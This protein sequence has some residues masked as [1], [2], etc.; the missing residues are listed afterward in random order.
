MYDVDKEKNNWLKPILILLGIVVVIF[1]VLFAVKA[2]DNNKK[3]DGSLESILL[4]AGKESFN[5]EGLPEA[6]GECRTVTLGSLVENDYIDDV[7]VFAT[8]DNAESY[9]KVCKLESGEYQYT[10]VLNCTDNKTSFTDWVVGTE[11]SL[12]PNKSDVR[13]TYLAER[14]EMVGDESKVTSTSKK[15]FYP[16]NYTSANKVKEY[17]V[18]KPATGYSYKTA[19]TSQAAKWYTESTTGGA[20]WN[21]GAYSGIEPSGYPVKINEKIVATGI[22][23]E[24]P[25]E[26]TN[27][28]IA[29]IA[30]YKYS[31]DDGTAAPYRF[32]CQSTT[33]QGDL[34]SFT[35]CRQNTNGYDKIAEI[36]YSCKGK[37]DMQDSSLN[38]NDVAKGTKCEMTTIK[39]DTTSNFC[40][41]YNGYSYVDK[42]WQWKN[43]ATTVRSY[44]PSGKTTAIE[45]KTYYIEAPIAG[46][47]K[48]ETTITSAFK[49]YKL[50]TTKNE[51]IDSEKEEWIKVTEDYV[52]E[53]ILVATLKSINFEVNNIND[54]SKNENLRYTVKLEYRSRIDE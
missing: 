43:E 2:C 25:A 34:Y 22:S 49:Y 44:Y 28:T 33:L 41:Q 32:K 39:C 38:T 21:N 42:E 12:I 31:I 6:N 40:K 50:V 18:T 26:A 11:D 15:Y 27:R 7:T 13:F 4:N 19:G 3:N 53:D 29:Q 17:Y 54:I 51:I 30:I 9:V 46:A 37:G 1:I 36:Y 23:Q 45:E 8:C 52:T 24:K 47:I 20:L 48:D 16:S 10:P 35:D 5:K 14:K